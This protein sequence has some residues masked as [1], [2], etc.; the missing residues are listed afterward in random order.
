MIRFGCWFGLGRIETVL[1]AMRHVAATC[2]AGGQVLLL[3]VDKTA[4]A[5]MRRG[6]R[7]GGHPGGRDDGKRAKSFSSS[8]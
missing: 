4:E 6:G 8:R 7:R 1:R 2:K 3:D 5:A